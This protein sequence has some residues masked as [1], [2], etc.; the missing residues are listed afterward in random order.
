M[1]QTYSSTNSTFD[2]SSVHSPLPWVIANWKM[3]PQ[4]QSA[5][6]QLID[7]L[8]QYP[9]PSSVN[10]AIAPPV[11]YLDTLKAATA[12]GDW[13]PYLAAQNLCAN[14]TSHG[15]FTGEVSASQL[16]DM[17]ADLVLV[18][19]SE[20][21]QYYAETDA[22]LSQKIQY[23]FEQGLS[24]IFCI[25]ESHEH[26]LAKQ[27]QQIISQQLE[28]LSPFAEQIPLPAD[29][30]ALPKLFIAYEPIWAIGTGLTPSVDE[31]AT[32]H[33]YISELLSTLQIYAPIVY[34]GSVNEKNAADIA[35]IPLV[36]GALVGGASLK[37]DSFCQIIDAF[38]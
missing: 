34:G 18:G 27:T 14:H 21:R 16:K 6:H 11:L 38:G 8:Q 23:A 17:G 10:V 37:A 2:N 36:S 33:N 3:N 9:A 7:E 32:V 29:S 31:I 12:Q 19:H 20:R 4:N 26:Y 24:V 13:Q 25:G 30:T 1:S 35:N 22:I 28:L 5:V 15:A